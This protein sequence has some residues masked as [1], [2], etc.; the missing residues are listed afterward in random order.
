MAAFV[1]LHVNRVKHPGFQ[2]KS[3]ASSISP[4]FIQG[5][6]IERMWESINFTT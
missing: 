6:A 1:R 3:P 4:N 5:S 2:R